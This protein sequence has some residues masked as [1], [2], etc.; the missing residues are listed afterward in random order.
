MPASPLRTWAEIDT[1]AWRGNYRSIAAAIRPAELVPVIKANAYGLGATEAARAFRSVGAKRFAVS[2]LEEGLQLGVFGLPILLLGAVL[3]EEVPDLLQAG[4]IA[5]VTDMAIAGLLSRTAERLRRNAVVHLKID[6]GMGRLGIPLGQARQLVPEIVA[7]PRLKVEGLFSHFP[8]AELTGGAT[9]SQ[10]TAVTD[11]LA[12][13]QEAGITFRYRHMANSPG[14]AHVPGAFRAPFNM[15]RVGID[16]HGHLSA[17]SAPYDLKPAVT[18]KA[19]LVAVRHLPLGATVS[20]G[21]HYTVTDPAGERVGVVAIGYADGYPR[22]LSGCGTV[23][24]RGMRCPIRGNVCMDFTMVSLQAVPDADV[25]DEVVLFGTQGEG[26][27]DINE[28]AEMAGTIPYELTCR[29][30]PRV[31]RIYVNRS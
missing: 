23:L 28:V 29:L 11:L 24:V 6:S 27:L 3:P 15:A 16:L 8:S 30:G 18:L 17:A 9:A 13:L 4:L 19:R 25:G 5:P 26:T 7:L 21:R 10:V 14:V 20:Y 22:H 31:K 12:D 1:S 2:C